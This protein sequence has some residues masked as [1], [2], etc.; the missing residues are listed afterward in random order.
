M[1]CLL[2]PLPPPSLPSLHHPS[3]LSLSLTVSTPLSLFLFPA[4]GG[5][6]EVVHARISSSSGRARDLAEQYLAVVQSSG[7]RPG[8]GR[9]ATCAS[10]AAAS[11]VAARVC[12]PLYL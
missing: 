7:R 12:Y 10:S 8:S 11:T 1:V 3:L 9:P 6:V 2:P 5:D 4:G